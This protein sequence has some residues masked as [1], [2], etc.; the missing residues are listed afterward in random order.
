[1]R[2][3]FKRSFQVLLLLVLISPFVLG[4]LNYAGF[5]IPEGRFLSDEE[6]IR[7]AVGWVNGEHVYIQ[8]NG[9]RKAYKSIPYNDVD[10]FLRQNPECCQV[11]TGKGRHPEDRPYPSIFARMGGIYTGDVNINYVANY[12]DDE[13]HK[14][15]IKYRRRISLSNC[16]KNTSD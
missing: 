9:E 2:K 1:M 6:K 4:G 13:G 12:M 10:D 5:C 14:Q 16:G 15:S 11:L 8:N 7:T 3:T